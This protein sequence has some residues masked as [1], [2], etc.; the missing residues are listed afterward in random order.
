MKKFALAVPILFLLTFFAFGQGDIETSKKNARQLEKEGK[1]A[2][3]LAELSEAIAVEPTNADLYIRRASVYLGLKETDAMKQDLI[4]AVALKPDDETTILSA[5]RVLFNAQIYG[6]E[7]CSSA[8]SMLDRYLA[9]HAD[10][11][12]VFNFRAINKQCAGDFFGAYQDFSRA[13]ELKPDNPLYQKSAAASL[14]NIGDSPQALELLGKMIA[15]SEAKLSAA[16]DAG[17]KWQLQFAVSR[18]YGSRSFVYEKQGNFEAAFADLNKMIEVM[19]HQ[20]SYI[21]RARAF[22]RQ[23]KYAEAINDY[24]EIIKFQ[25]KDPSNYLERGDLYFR[26]GKFSDALNDY[27]KALTLNEHARLKEMLERR[28]E[29]V[30]QKMRENVIQPK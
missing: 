8:V 25:P 11:D 20:S 6:R 19:P 13:A 5:A 7:F 14:A 17:K 21:M 22:V 18:F 16:N 10:A 28:I 24:N 9:D 2:E 12:Q 15:E 30:K 3:A 4:K 26:T 23:K 29:Q 1:S 27:E